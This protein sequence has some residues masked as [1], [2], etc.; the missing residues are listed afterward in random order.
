MQHFCDWRELGHYHYKVSKRW[1][2]APSQNICLGSFLNT[3]SGPVGVFWPGAGN[4]TREGEKMC[5]ASRLAQQEQIHGVGPRGLCPHCPCYRGI[6][7]LGLGLV[8]WWG[9]AAQWNW[10]IAF[11]LVSPER[12]ILLVCSKTAL[13]SNLSGVNSGEKEAWMKITVLVQAKMQI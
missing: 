7:H 3:L 2:I 9:L 10:G 6:C 13:W 12:M 5:R 1:N 11:V 4:C 8:W